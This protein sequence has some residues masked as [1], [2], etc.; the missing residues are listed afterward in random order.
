M[1]LESNRDGELKLPKA[2]PP[3]LSA[4]ACPRRPSPASIGS[5]TP[6]LRKSW[7]QGMAPVGTLQNDILSPTACEPNE[8]QNHIAFHG[9]K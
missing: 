7:N 9:V 4:V 8:V 5:D 3:S 2:I 6:P 1:G